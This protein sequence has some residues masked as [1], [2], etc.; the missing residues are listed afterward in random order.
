[1]KILLTN[2]DGI[3]CQGILTLKHVLE[4]LGK[5]TIYMVAPEENRSGISHGITMQ[6]PIRL[7]QKEDTV[8]ACSGTPAD[9]VIVSLLGDLAIQPDMVISGINEGPNLGTDIIYSGTAS[10][11]RQ[12]ALHGIPSLAV[13]IGAHTKPFQYET[14]A[15]YIADHLDELRSL[16]ETDTFLN[17]NVPNKAAKI[18]EYRLTYPSRRRYNDQVVRFN[19]PDG[20]HYCFLEGGAIETKEDDGSDWHVVE[21]GLVSISKIYI[22]PVV[23]EALK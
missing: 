15:R 9:C 18:D 10:A 23:V 5:H 16:W 6:G 8:W 13:S 7:R 1:M 22:H 17:I 19:A 12:G 3:G 21:Q 20:H 14:A 4:A 11:A 2:D